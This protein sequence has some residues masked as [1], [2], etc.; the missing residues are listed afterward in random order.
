MQQKI[1]IGIANIFAGAGRVVDCV[2]MREEGVCE[3]ALFLQLFSEVRLSTL[4]KIVIVFASE[5]A[6]SAAIHFRA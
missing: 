6:A 3:P 2:S 4:H 1:N 5:N